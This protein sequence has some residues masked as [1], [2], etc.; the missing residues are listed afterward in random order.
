MECL[1]LQFESFDEELCKY[2]KAVPVTKQKGLHNDTAGISEK[3]RGKKR[4][5][6]DA[7]IASNGKIEPTSDAE[8]EDSNKEV[9]QERDV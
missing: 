1:G 8:M 7:G 5:I 2:L 3:R 6:D 4:K 9:K